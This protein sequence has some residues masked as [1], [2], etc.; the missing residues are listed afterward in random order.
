MS[1]NNETTNNHVYEIGIS[2]RIGLD[3]HSLSNIGNRGNVLLPRK[4]LLANG[5]ETDALSGASL[6]HHH[7]EAL[8]F[9][10][11][12]NGDYLCPACQNHDSLRAAAWVNSP[13]YSRPDE[14]LT[15]SQ[16][17]QCGLCD[18]HGFLIPK[19]EG[20]QNSVQRWTKY[21][22]LNYSMGLAIPE[23]FAELNQLHTRQA[24]K[25]ENAML[26]ERP[27]RSGLYGLC[28]RYIPGWLGVDTRTMEQ[29]LTDEEVRIRRHKLVLNG[30]RGQLLT[31]R[32]AT[33]ASMLPHLISLEGAVTIQHDP[34]NTAPLFSPLD[35]QYIEILQSFA[36]NSPDVYAPE[37]LTFSDAQTFNEIMIGLMENTLPYARVPQT[38]I[39]A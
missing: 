14:A 37:V 38:I 31:P 17:L 26:F 30:L 20:Q 4:V 36:T 32:G 28:I 16:L 21:A 7:A 8:A 34:G 13:E 1:T 10:L 39:S 2:V 24:V 3:A 6:K 15:M 35:D 22:V 12:A 33:M 19:V 11:E 25:N 27:S 18:T 23:S 29:V 9:S 5:I